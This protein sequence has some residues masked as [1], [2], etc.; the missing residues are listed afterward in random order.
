MATFPIQLFVDSTNKVKSTQSGATYYNTNNRLLFK[1]GD[2]ASFEV[3]FLNR[4]ANAPFR[5]T[6]GAIVQVAMKQLNAYGSA[7]PYAVFGSTSNTPATDSDPYVI[8]VDILG[9]TLSALFTGATEPSYVDLMFE[10]SWSEDS[11]ASWNSTCE[12]IVARIYNEVISTATNVPPIISA[13]S[14]T[15][16]YNHSFRLQKDQSQTIAVDLQ[17]L[18]GLKLGDIAQYKIT[19]GMTPRKTGVAAD[20][21]AKCLVQAEF[22][23]TVDLSDVGNYDNVLDLP[24]IGTLKA[25]TKYG[26]NAENCGDFSLSVTG[27]GLSTANAV[28]KQAAALSFAFGSTDTTPTRTVDL[29]DI[30]C[31]FN[32]QL[33]GKH[34]NWID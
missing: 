32:V 7:T 33:V 17:P 22:Y 27:G 8:S 4:T 19:M 9:A 13:L 12:P 15:T 5:L 14:L 1:R 21:N 28:F 20:Y 10:L 31:F 30:V 23:A 25:L 18:Y 2:S 24:T 29:Y 3:K 26:T 16:S 6:S 11:G 34:Y